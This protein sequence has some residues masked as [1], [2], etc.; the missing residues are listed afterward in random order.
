MNDSDKPKNQSSKRKGQAAEAESAARAREGRTTDPEAATEPESS[1]SARKAQAPK[2]KSQARARKN[3]G[4]ANGGSSAS[5]SWENEPEDDDDAPGSSAPPA[6]N[7]RGAL[8]RLEDWERYRIDDSWVPA[9]GLR[10]DELVGR[11]C[12]AL[13]MHGVCVIAAQALLGKTTLAHEVLRVERL[14]GQASFYLSLEGFG[15][16]GAVRKLR[17]FGK[18]L[19]A[20]DAF[21]RLTLVVDDVPSMGEEYGQRLGALVRGF[22]GAGARIL[23]CSSPEVGAAYDMFPAH[24][25]LDSRDLVAQGGEYV[26]WFERLGAAQIEDLRR[27]THGMVPLLYAARESP[28]RFDAEELL[29][30]SVFKDIV[31][32]MALSCVS[33]ME[34][35]EHRQLAQAMI[36]LGSGELRELSAMGLRM[37][38]ETAFGLAADYPLLGVDP[39]DRSFSVVACPCAHY[40]AALAHA[41]T[42]GTSGVSNARIVWSCSCALAQRGDF[43]RANLLALRFVDAAGREE[44]VRRWPC[45]LA[46][47]GGMAL[48]RAVVGQSEPAQRVLPDPRSAQ[49]NARA[50]DLGL[51]VARVIVDALTPRGL[52]K[53]NARL[54]QLRLLVERRQAGLQAAPDQPAP[55]QAQPQAQPQAHATP[56]AL[57]APA[58]TPEALRDHELCVQARLVA[59]LRM[60]WDVPGSVT[61]QMAQDPDVPLTP[62]SRT[63][64]QQEENAAC[65]PARYRVPGEGAVTFGLRVL[66]GALALLGR[67][68]WARTCRLLV[69]SGLSLEGTSSLSAALRCTFNHATRLSGDPLG[70]PDVEAHSLAMAALQGNDLAAYAHRDRLVGAAIEAYATPD[71]ETEAERLLARLGRAD[72]QVAAYA[73]NVVIALA[74]VRRGAHQR[75]R[76]R[77][78]RAQ[79]LASDLRLDFYQRIG[80]LVEAL[81]LAG[82]GYLQDA[83]RWAS[84]SILPSKRGE[85]D[86]VGML[87]L[88]FSAALSQNPERIAAMHERL[89]A[90]SCP[91]GMQGLALALR[92]AVARACPKGGALPLRWE[93]EL[94]REEARRPARVAASGPAA[95]SAAPDTCLKLRTLGG[96]E[97]TRAGVPVSGTG[98]KQTPLAV[99]AALATARGHALEREQ[100]CAIVWPR[101]D[102]QRARERLYTALSVLRKALGTASP[103]SEGYILTRP[104]MIALNAGEVW[105]DAD[106]LERTAREV[107]GHV[108]RGPEVVTACGRLIDLYRGELYVPRG[109]DRQFFEARAN[110]LKG[111]YVDA[112]VSGTDAVLGSGYAREALWLAKSAALADP[113]R[114]DTILRLMQAHILVREFREVKA[115]YERYARYVV[116]VQD[117]LPS[118]E[119][120]GLYATALRELG[121]SR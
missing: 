85:M 65:D 94:A 96:L 119:L 105:V 71:A 93:Q 2:P 118:K 111:V 67:G 91:L 97:V 46:A 82:E 59:L 108:V 4:K 78:R 58:A 47:H 88:Y 69:A 68:E 32:P 84:L 95:A 98:R 49:E 17:L 3:P 89:D 102:P 107:I 56:D 18:A 72:G 81:S 113:K 42:D 76:A 83:E 33:S 75:A 21:K 106:E 7:A 25:R 45:E 31:G 22:V 16:S 110:E 90:S 5:A 52:T 44:L 1:T 38:A 6:R 77:A 120:R 14:Q 116:E 80:N 87:A 30:S 9:P 55:G 23:L 103:G 109:A 61:W 100:I 73:L 41:G 104:G 99:L 11:V 19:A 35:Q 92:E 117:A 34:M 36:A 101:A 54:E 27:I 63:S 114:Q 28:L 53:A 79:Q 40:E 74:D 51:G 64:A 13:R 39:Y 24:A 26:R 43:G 62:A 121:E 8:T 115:V 66:V 15:E 86:S 48:L 12:D 60:Q 10:R 20:N 37:D 29:R 70:Y 112:L 50:V 57:P